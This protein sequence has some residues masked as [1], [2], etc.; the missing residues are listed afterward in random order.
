[1]SDPPTVLFVDDEPAVHEA[2]ARNL[3]RR[4][5]SWTP[6]F[7]QDPRAAL[8]QATRSP[9]AVAVLDL[10][11]PE[12]DGLAL[13]EKMRAAGV[14]CPILILS[15]CND[16]AAAQAA[17]N[18][19]KAFRY[20]V[21][22]CPT[23]DLI[24]GVEEALAQ[25]RP[26]GQGT[27]G[28]GDQALDRL[29]VGVVVIDQGGAVVFANQRGGALLAARDGLMLDSAGVCRAERRADSEALAAAR[30]EAVA[31]QESVALSIER[32]EAATPLRLVLM[33]FDEAGRILLFVTDP[34]A[35]APLSPELIA[36]MFGLTPSE[37]R[38]TAALAGGLDLTEAAEACSVTKTTARS[39]LKQIFMKVGVSRQ[40]ELV[41]AV[42]SAAA[43]R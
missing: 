42:L 14:D 27:A 26:A 17:I 41:Q 40:A 35:P 10:L 16:F 39:Y 23:D 37:A 19:A 18:R 36:Q 29:A 32:T 33:P 4:Q 31:Q 15:G 11:M 2:L 1:M 43:A 3:R 5:I 7:Q 28:V 20:Y 25:S 30:R 9:P 34:D 21:K 6:A 8:A 38:L 22:P 12:L 13:A 24:A